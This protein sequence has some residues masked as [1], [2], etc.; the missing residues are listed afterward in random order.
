MNGTFYL[1]WHIE[2][3]SIRNDELNSWHNDENCQLIFCHFLSWKFGRLC[4]RAC[5]RVRNGH[6][7]NSLCTS[8]FYHICI[9][10][11]C[12]LLLSAG[13]KIV[14]IRRLITIAARTRWQF[15]FVDG[16]AQLQ[17]LT[18]RRGSV[19]TAPDS[20]FE[21]TGSNLNAEIGYL[22]VSLSPSKKVLRLYLRPATTTSFH[23]LFNPTFT[24]IVVYN[25]KNQKVRLLYNSKLSAHEIVKTNIAL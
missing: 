2:A 20:Y 13:N 11:P 9:L 12:P 18:R 6:F 21:G 14:A 7:D 1:I 5:V 3:N 17:R 19:V 22:E 25:N 4:V 10:A 16:S 23:I 15:W 8:S 24:V